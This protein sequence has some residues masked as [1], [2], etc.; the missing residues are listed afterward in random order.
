MQVPLGQ[1]AREAWHAPGPLSPSAEATVTDW[2]LKFHIKIAVLYS[3]FLPQILGTR[4]QIET[5]AGAILHTKHINV[6]IIFD[7]FL[8]WAFNSPGTPTEYGGLAGKTTHEPAEKK[9]EEPP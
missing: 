5:S 6:Q 4:R 8:L 1:S 2:N 9:Q 3:E 7:D